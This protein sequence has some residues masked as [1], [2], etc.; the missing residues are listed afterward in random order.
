MAASTI[1]SLSGPWSFLWLW[2]TRASPTLLFVEDCV[3]VPLQPPVL[4]HVAALL[5]DHDSG[6]V[7]VARG[8]DGH[9]GGVDDSQPVDA[10]HAQLGVDH[11]ARVVGRPHAAGAGLVVLGACLTAHSALPV[12]VAAER[13]VLTARYWGPIQAEAIPRTGW[14]KRRLSVNHYSQYC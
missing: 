8:D 5:G 13:Q 2:P 7:G 1:T 10:V 9:D 11:G 14:N 4:D 12:C 6:R 3:W